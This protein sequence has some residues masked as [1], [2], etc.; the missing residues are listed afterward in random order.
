MTDRLSCL[1]AG[2][3]NPCENLALEEY[4]L[5]IVQSGECI[6][7][8]WQNQKTV[9]VGRNQNCWK[10]CR[11]TALEDDGGHL[12]RRLS[13]GGAVFHDLGNLNFTFLVPREDFDVDKQT[14]VIME[15]VRSFG[16][17]V[18]RSGRNDLTVDGRKFSGHAYYRTETACYH[19]GTLL[20]RDSGE[21]MEKYLSVSREKLRAKNVSSVRARVCSLD[22]FVRGITVSAMERALLTAFSQVYELPFSPLADE[23]LDAA[24]LSALTEKY[25]SADWR[26]GRKFPFEYEL[27]RRFDWGEVLLQLHVED[28]RIADLAVW[29]DALDTA[30]PALV[31]QALLGAVFE[32]RAVRAALLSIPEPDESLAQALADTGSLLLEAM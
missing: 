8:L 3:T 1:F 24:A 30:Y 31:R 5:D 32:A 27:G 29:S 11:V 12:A 10:E 13:G 23:R 6:L 16:I 4:L 28:G 25:A 26:Y 2:G 17:D 18:A 19:H 21:E 20:L 15:A 22:S 7:Y 9:V 14:R